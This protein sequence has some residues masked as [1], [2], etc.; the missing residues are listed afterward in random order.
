MVGKWG[1]VSLPEE[2]GSTRDCSGEAEFYRRDGYVLTGQSSSRWWIEGDVLVRQR[3]TH[4]I[5][6]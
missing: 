1:W 5:P 4:V 2:A 6:A 3:V